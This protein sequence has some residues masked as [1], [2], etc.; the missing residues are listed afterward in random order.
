LIGSGP[1][2]TGAHSTG[3]MMSPV[4]KLIEVH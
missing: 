3:G 1:A 2:T 4:L